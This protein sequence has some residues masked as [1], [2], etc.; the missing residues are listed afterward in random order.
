MTNIKLVNKSPEKIIRLISPKMSKSP[1]KKTIITMMNQ[2]VANKESPR[3]LLK[4][5]LKKKIVTRLFY[6]KSLF[7]YVIKL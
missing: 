5:N 7:I 3:V 4:I 6:F 1:D 2:S